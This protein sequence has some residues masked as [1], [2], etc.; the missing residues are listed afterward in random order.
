MALTN[1]TL[2]MGHMINLNLLDLSYNKIPCLYNSRMRDINTI[3]GYTPMRRNISSILE[4]NL[5]DNPLR[6]RCSCLE[7]YQWMQKVRPYITFIKFN[8]YQCTFDNGQKV[9]LTDLNLIV[10]T[11]NSQCVSTN[12]S[13]VLRTTTAIVTVYMFIILAMTLYRYRHTLRYIWLKHKMHKAYVE[14][15]ILDPKYSFDAFISC[16][17]SGA[18][19]VKRNFLPKLENEQAGLKFCIVQRD[20]IVGATIID[21]IVHSINKSRKVVYVFSQNFLKSGWCK[22]ELLIGHQES[23][24]RG[25]NI[26]ICIFMPDIIYDKLPDRFRFILNHVTCIKWPRDPAAQQVFWIMLKRA[27]LDGEAS[28]YQI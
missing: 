27:L 25:K 12:W 5:S 2:K 19:W 14:R 17:R 28:K 15:Q 18:I 3:I 23:L 8:S 13:L 24:S 26:L 22:E 21:N 1:L 20:F 7:F 11:L 6:S 4:I 9:F 10:E 16:D